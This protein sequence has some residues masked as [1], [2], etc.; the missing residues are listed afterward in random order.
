VT[1]VEAVRARFAPRCHVPECHCRCCQRCRHFRLYPG[2]AAPAATAAS[3]HSGVI[4]RS[5]SP[6]PFLGLYGIS[7]LS[8]QAAWA[9]GYYIKQDQ[10]DFLTL[11]ERWNGGRWGI[12]PGPSAAP[13]GVLDAVAAVSPANVWAVGA[14]EVNSAA[15]PVTLIDHWDGSAWRVVPS[16]VMPGLLDA[17]AVASPSDIWAVGFR[18]IDNGLKPERTLVE[19]WD[20]AR[21]QVVPSPTPTKYG[22]GL[23][24]V[25][26]VSPDDVWAT[27]AVNNPWSVSAPSAT[28]LW[29]A[30]GGYRTLVMHFCPAG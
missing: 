19:H 17:L 8:N 27:G 25:T 5:P 22:D 29:A 10:S 30:G 1:F 21:W 3:C 7:A 2:R 20:G 15:S 18:K 26:V 9:V 12:M 16:P 6:G 24:G 4:T 28:D 23:G 14:R 13:H 11:I